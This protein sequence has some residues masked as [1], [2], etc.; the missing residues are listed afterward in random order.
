MATLNTAGCYGLP[1]RGAI[2][3]GCM[4]DFVVMED[5]RK[6]D[7]CMVFKNGKRIANGQARRAVES[8]I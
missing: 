7:I 3:P 8:Y 4:A 5:I 1:D 2:A 6:V